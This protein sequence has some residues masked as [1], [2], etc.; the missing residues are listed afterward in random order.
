LKILHRYIA[1]EV[2]SGIGLVFLGLVL[3][4][5]FFDLIH[6]LNDLGRGNYTL[7]RM[8]VFVLLAM[9]A[10][11]YELFPISALVGT[12]Y[13]LSSLSQHSEISVMRAAG[14]SKIQLGVALGR[15]GLLLVGMSFLLGEWIMPISES[16]AQQWRLSALNSLVATQF[17]SGLWV[18][19]EKN[20]V[21]IQEILPDTSLRGIKIYT[22]DQGSRLKSIRFAERGE[23]SGEAGTWKL[24]N[25]TETLFEGDQARLVRNP[26]QPW[27]SMLTPSVLSVLLVAP[28]QMSLWNLFTYIK[29]LRENQQRTTRFEIAQWSKALYPFGIIVMMWL[30][31]PFAMNRSRSG[32]FGRQIMLGIGLGLSF[33]LTIRLFSFLGELN[34]W[35]PWVSTLAPNIAFLMMAF[36]IVGLWGAWYCNSLYYNK[37]LFPQGAASSCGSSG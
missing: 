12:L 20:F 17:R 16:A 36:L 22:F 11:A 26:S 33:Y 27:K 29:H 30:A 37:T 13:G 28:E 6:E 21:N 35:S 32:G 8:F 23:Y 15:V 19:D 1:R 25:V 5:A 34:N 7:G 31:M 3:L 9:P 24:N 18:K 10:H 4:F 2:L 14:M